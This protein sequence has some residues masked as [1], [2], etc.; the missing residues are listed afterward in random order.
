MVFE[1]FKVKFKFKFKVKV[2]VKVLGVV[3]E[4]VS[5]SGWKL[6]LGDAFPWARGEPTV[7][8]A[9]LVVSPDRADPAGKSRN[10]E[11]LLRVKAQR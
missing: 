3:S 8:C 11:R 6:Q 2:K 7:R 9:L 10:E 4:F 1:I 5:G